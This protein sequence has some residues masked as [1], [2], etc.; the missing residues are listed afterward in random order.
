MGKHQEGFLSVVLERIPRACFKQLDICTQFPHW[1]HTTAYYKGTACLFQ[2][3]CTFLAYQDDINFAELVP[4]ICWSS[5]D[6]V[7]L[8]DY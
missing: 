6:S 4:T 7:H 1:N 5:F 2:C 8:P 3:V